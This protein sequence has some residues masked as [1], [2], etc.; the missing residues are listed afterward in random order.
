MDGVLVFFPVS[1]GPC[2]QVCG[3]VKAYQWG[4]TGGFVGYISFG[5]STIDSAYVS[6]LAQ[7]TAILNTTFG[8]LQLGGGKPLNQLLLMPVL[9]TPLRIYE[10]LILFPMISSASQGMYMVTPRHMGS[11]QATFSVMAKTATHQAH[12]FCH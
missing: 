4:F 10:P 12:V 1:E 5:Q 7:H 6:G 8:H 3:R 11:S 2:S 9:A